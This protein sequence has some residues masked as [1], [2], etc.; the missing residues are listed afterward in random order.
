MEFSLPKINIEVINK[1][2]TT[3]QVEESTRTVTSTNT[4]TNCDESSSGVELIIGLIKLFDPEHG[5]IISNDIGLIG[6]NDFKISPFREFDGTIYDATLDNSVKYK[7][8]ERFKVLH[9]DGFILFNEEVEWTGIIK[10]DDNDNY[11]YVFGLSGRHISNTIDSFFGDEDTDD[12]I[13]VFIPSVYKENN[14][15][16]FTNDLELMQTSHEYRY[17]KDLYYDKISNTITIDDVA[18]RLIEIDSENKIYRIYK[19]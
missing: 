17:K 15:K 4:T 14:C 16:C 13:A 1:Q 3:Q 18:Y 12:S 2:E 19:K 5:I 7:L 8:G 11:G 9:S 6:N 10:N